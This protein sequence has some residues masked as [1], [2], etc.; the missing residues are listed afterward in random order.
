MVSHTF[1]LQIAFFCKPISYFKKRNF[2]MLSSE[3][4]IIYECEVSFAVCKLKIYNSP[5]CKSE[6]AEDYI[7]IDPKFVNL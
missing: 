2:Q 1:L 7:L 3:K 5:Q 4:K 6:I